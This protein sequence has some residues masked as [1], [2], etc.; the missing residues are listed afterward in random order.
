MTKNTETM[1]AKTSSLPTTGQVLRFLLKC[2]GE[3]EGKGDWAKHKRVERLVKQCQQSKSAS[4]ETKAALIDAVAALFDKSLRGELVSGKILEMSL[5]QRVQSALPRLRDGNVGEKQFTVR[6]IF[7][8]VYFIEHQEWLRPQLEAA[9]TPDDAS[10][11]WVEHA[12]HFYTRTLGDTVRVNPS[13]LDGLPP[14]LSWNLPT[15]QPDG[16]VKWPLCHAFEWLEGLIDTQDGDAM[17]RIVFPNSEKLRS[18][19]CYKRMM[20]GENLL[21]LE[22]IE[23]V[24]QH[25][26]QFKKG[27]AAISPEK[28]NAVLLWCRALQFALKTV[29]RKFHLDSVWLLVE[30]HNR[31]T[32]SH[33]KFL[34]E[35][36]KGGEKYGRTNTS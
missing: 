3:S 23:R 6:L 1:K 15:I 14:G 35:R 25:H 5:G 20:R 9:H 28:L 10:W 16:T 27:S 26:W 33:F 11:E 31:A 36:K 32:T 29:E 19:M 12:S 2:F 21:G 24:A 30:W 13:L 18:A 22:K 8:I 4:R 17:P 7:W 34:A